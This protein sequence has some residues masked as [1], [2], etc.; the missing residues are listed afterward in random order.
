MATVATATLKTQKTESLY[1]WEGRDKRGQRVKGTTTASDETALRADL[2]RQGIAPS[3]VRKQRESIR[4]GKVKPADVAVFSRQLS[5][6]LI[7]GIPMVQ[8]F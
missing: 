1:A 5:T 8:A 7:A 4:G 3:R 6:M 2:R